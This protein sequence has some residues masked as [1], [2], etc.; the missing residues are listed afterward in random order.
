VT[1]IFK[2]TKQ[3]HFMEGE[4]AAGTIHAAFTYTHPLAKMFAEGKETLYAE[5]KVKG[6]FVDVKKLVT[7]A[8][9]NNSKQKKEKVKCAE[10]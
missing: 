4:N 3:Q 9:F 1:T 2:V 5:C 7:E 8:D 10:V 6:N